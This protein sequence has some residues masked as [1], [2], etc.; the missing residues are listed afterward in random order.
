MISPPV[1]TRFVLALLAV[2]L[3]S[4]TVVSQ[5]PEPSAAFRRLDTNKDRQLTPDEVRNR[6]LFAII[7]TNRDGLISIAEDRAFTSRDSAQQAA[8]RLPG[9]V[10]LVVD[11]P[12]ADNENPRQ[13]LDLLLPRKNIPGHKPP[14]I[15]YIHGGAWRQGD[16]SSGRHYLASFVEDGRY[17]AATL[18]YRLS[19]EATWPAQIHDCKAAIRWLR[20]HADKYGFDPDRIGVMGHSAGGHLAIMLGVTNRVRDLEGKLGGHNDA[21][22]KVLCVVDFYGP[23]ELLVMD[24]YPGQM[25]HND[26]DSPES[27]LVGGPLQERKSA[28]VS[29][30]PVTHVTKHAAPVL[31]VHGSRDR[32]VPFNQSVRLLAAFHS[33]RVPAILVE[34]QEGGHGGF[35]SREVDRRVMGFFSRHLLGL[36]A[37]VPA[38]PIRLTP[39]KK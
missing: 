30:S 16:K 3:A 38:T 13:T 28:A 33:A 32:L 29:A 37:D 21:S 1:S 9:S 2:M 19:S 12:Y 22:S 4:T 5:E 27:Q 25:V 39:Q 6:R 7:D 23:T 35:R 31:M 24:D 11:V 15:V 20:A 10:R 8:G 34:I 36:K 18:G 17:A 26:S 14:L